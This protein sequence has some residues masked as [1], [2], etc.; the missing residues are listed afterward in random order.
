M[1]WTSIIRYFGSHVY[2]SYLRPDRT[3]AYAAILWEFADRGYTTIS[4]LRFAQRVANREA[5]A[6]KTLV[7]RH[8]ID[9]DPS[10]AKIWHEIEKSVGFEA[11]YYFR[12]RTADVG[13]MRQ[14][15]AEDVEVGYHYEEIATY[16]KAFLLQSGAEIEVHMPQ[17]R[18]RFLCN[19]EILRRKTGIPIV[20]AAAHGDFMNRRLLISNDALLADA[21]LRRRAG[22]YC[23]A[24]DRSYLDQ[25]VSRVSDAPYPVEWKQRSGKTLLEMM[26]A[27]DGPIEILTH[28]RWWR[29]SVCS[30]FREDSLRLILDMTYRAGLHAPRLTDFADRI[31]HLT[32]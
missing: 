17:I 14:L 21:D 31:S 18:D 5:I 25:I 27:G 22:I 24:Y 15:A 10:Y 6:P 29:R 26:E 32:K 1:R 28:P 7:L 11:S 3:V 16:A 9:S 20:T 13:I 19:L 2:S 4:I 23:E 30:N 8:D 12:L